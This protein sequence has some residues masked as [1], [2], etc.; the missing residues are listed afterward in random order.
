MRAR[1][2]GF[3]DWI[4]MRSDVWEREDAAVLG[5]GYYDSEWFVA[6]ES[7]TTAVREFLARC[8]PGLGEAS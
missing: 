7:P 3:P 1:W 4:V 6:E 2:V 8:A 5:A